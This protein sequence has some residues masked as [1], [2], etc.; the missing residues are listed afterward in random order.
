MR[1]LTFLFHA[2]VQ[3]NVGGK[4]YEVSQSLIDQYPNTILSLANSKPER[5]NKNTPIFIDRN[6][7]RFQYV[8]DYMRDGSVQLPMTIS[9]E[10]LLKDMEYYGFDIDPD[11]ITAYE[12][13][14]N[15]L[16][17]DRMT[18][19]AFM[20]DVQRDS[21]SY[22][23]YIDRGS[24]RDISTLGLHMLHRTNDEYEDYR[25]TFSTTME[26][27]GL[28]LEKIDLGTDNGICDIKFKRVPNGKKMQHFLPLDY[29]SD[30][31][32]SQRLLYEPDEANR[33]ILCKDRMT[34]L[35]FMC[36]AKG[37]RNSYSFLI[38]RIFDEKGAPQDVSALGLHILHNNKHT[39][40]DNYYCTLT[41]M[42]TRFGLKLI[43]MNLISGNRRCKVEYERVSNVLEEDTE[44]CPK[45]SIH[46]SN[47]KAI[48]HQSDEVF[49][50][51]LREDRMALLAFMCHEVGDGYLYSISI[52]NN[53]PEAISSLGIHI[54]RNDKKEV[55]EYED[56]RS[57]FSHMMAIIG[58]ELLKIDFNADKEKCDIEF[59]RASD[60]FVDKVKKLN[61]LA[62]TLKDQTVEAYR[63]ILREERMTLLAFMCDIHGE[64]KSF[65][66][67]DMYF[68][69]LPERYPQDISSAGL[70]IL[71][72]EKHPEHESYFRTLSKTMLALGL[73]LIEIGQSPMESFIINF[74][75]L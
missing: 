50:S 63:N 24:P 22:R 19:L 55:Q 36:N 25:D 59:A 70:H 51:I 27:L 58:F 28:N 23:F 49:R 18:L 52:P 26:R 8:L 34:L 54:L 11:R 31:F 64:R 60:A 21:S 38:P 35:A 74:S 72:N 75:R 6:G 42:M 65:M 41:E 62:F 46:S 57:T 17:Q 20:C 40:Y 7:E 47:T 43:K 71:L 48:Q 39:E 4:M 73:E 29:C 5:T 45:F 12:T 61:S 15:F 16:C 1:F 3:Y 9:K 2:M 56:Y 32:N 10:S 69:G 44:F 30:S 13:R 66:D 53:G 68:F 67:H 37:D 14:S 33:N